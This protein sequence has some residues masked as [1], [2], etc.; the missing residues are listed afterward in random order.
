MRVLIFLCLLTS[1]CAW[2]TPPLAYLLSIDNEPAGRL[3]ITRQTTERGLRITTDTYIERASLF[4]TEKTHSRRQEQFENNNLVGY[5][6][7]INAPDTTFH[8]LGKQQGNSFWIHA[9]VIKST[10]Q[11]E[12]DDLM[13]GA[14]VI[15]SNAVPYVGTALT[16]TSLLADEKQQG[17]FSFN[18]SQYQHSIPELPH[19]SLSLTEPVTVN[20]LDTDMIR[21]IE[22]TLTPQGTETVQIKGRAIEVSKL[23]VRG[24]DFQ[25]VYRV[26][27]DKLGPYL[28]ALEGHNQTLGQ[29]S[30]QLKQS[31]L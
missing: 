27:K 13:A 30:V 4:E 15:L 7:R 20:L 2:A 28:V 1:F 25:L 24:E 31:S 19:L 21:V 18:A 8:T 23:N 11:L 26:A 14:F 10:Q 6:T 16:V 22:V 3:N 5:E 9:N 12:E 17:A 29:F